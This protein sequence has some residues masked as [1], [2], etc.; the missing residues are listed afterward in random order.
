MVRS[1]EQPE[2]TATSASK[3]RSARQARR[4]LL[5]NRLGFALPHF[6]A[7]LSVMD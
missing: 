1:Y 4:F 2:W 7:T 6:T 5:K 3:L